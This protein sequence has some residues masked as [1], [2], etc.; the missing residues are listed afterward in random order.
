MRWLVGIDS[1]NLSA[2]AASF[3]RW[4]AGRS[5]VD[6]FVGVHVLEHAATALASELRPPIQGTTVHQ[7]AEAAL[8]PLRAESTFAEVAVVEGRSIEEGLE[9]AA[10][11]QGADAF[12]LGRRKPA[13]QASMLR[14]GRVARRM[15][16]ALPRPVVIVPPDL[17]GRMIPGGPI[18]VGVDLSSASRGAVALAR[19][20]ARALDLELLAAHVLRM[21]DALEP[22][23]PAESWDD[24]VRSRRDR[25]E[26]DLERWCAEQGLGDARRVVAHGSPTGCLIDLAKSA[27]ASMIAVGSRGLKTLD[28]I[29]ESSVG[30]ELAASAPIPVAVV[31]SDWTASPAPA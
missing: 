16:R 23:I 26:T 12:I 24:R 8:D 21:P 22:I 30:S 27:K 13:D 1:R 14:L 29:F 10:E 11:E 15:L 18:L 28:R 31:P 3:A 4:C 5:A 25:T 6:T 17:R 2:G 19:R 7:M 20:M 9:C